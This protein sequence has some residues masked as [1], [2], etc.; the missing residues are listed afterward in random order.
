MRRTASRAIRTTDQGL[1][2]DVRRR[3]LR[4]FAI[5]HAMRD[6]GVDSLKI[7]L[8]QLGKAR[9]ILQRRLDLQPLIILVLQVLF[10]QRLQS[11]LRGTWFLIT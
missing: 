7:V 1:V 5:S 10:F 3:V 9:R 4:F 8:V 6:V 11:V 2:E